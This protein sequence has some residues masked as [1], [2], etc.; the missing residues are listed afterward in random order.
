MKNIILY[1]KHN[2]INQFI[3]ILLSPFMNYLHKNILLPKYKQM[4]NIQ[5]NIAHG[6]YPQYRKKDH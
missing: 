2:I 1:E 5:K 4:N 3:G 6:F